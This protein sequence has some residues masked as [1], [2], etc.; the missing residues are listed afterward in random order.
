MSE[1]Q[2][3][4]LD[5]RRQQRLDRIQALFAWQFY[6]EASR[7]QLTP[8]AASQFIPAHPI[9][10][11]LA[12]LDD[13]ILHYAPKHTLDTFNKIDLAILRQALYELEYA[14]VPPAVVIDEAVEIAKEYGGDET[15]SFVHGVLG[16]F[17]DERRQREQSEKEPDA[18]TGNLPT[19]SPEI[20]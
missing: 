10:E 4:V 16:N 17:V 12:D 7:A 1:E 14:D 2:A 19:S 20:E 9:I 5:P 13:I 6:D 3:Q 18:A 15:P 8:E 11:H